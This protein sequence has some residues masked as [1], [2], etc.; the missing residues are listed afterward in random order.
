MRIQHVILF[1]CVF[2]LTVCSKID[3]LNVDGSVEVEIFHSYSIISAPCAAALQSGEIM[4]AFL[5]SDSI[6]GRNT[7]IFMTRSDFGKLW[8]RPEVVVETEREIKALNICTLENNT[9]LMNFIHVADDPA[10]YNDTVGCFMVRSVDGG[11]TSSTP[12][13]INADGYDWRATTAEI[14]ELRNGVLSL[15]M[16]VRVTAGSSSIIYYSS[17]DRG[18]T[19]SSSAVIADDPWDLIDFLNPVMLELPDS[20]LICMFQSSEDRGLIYQSSSHDAGREWSEPAFSGLYGT[21]PDLIRT[22]EG[23]LLCAYNDAWPDCVSFSSSYD[24]GKTWE[25][26]INLNHVKKNDFIPK[27]IELK[28]RLFI[29]YDELKNTENNRTFSQINGLIIQHSKLE[30]PKGFTASVNGEHI[31]LRWNRVKDAR[32]YNVYREMV[33][34]SLQ[35]PGS[36]PEMDRI[37][38]PLNNRFADSDIWPG[39]IYYYR[40][41]AVKGKGRIVTGSAGESL[42][43]DVLGVKMR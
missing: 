27:I 38:L 6:T 24:F 16:T 1:G 36:M 11:Q 9:V 26:E 19:W 40:I 34:D 31:I 25:S 42:P 21:T 20:S 22:R 23:M 30:S 7:K 14:L 39:R 10:V 8:S 41:T 15:A 12:K 4:V 29:V 33:T 37:A 13:L 17:I 28:D 3:N 2:L 35:S 43:S 18:K 32:Y 5:E